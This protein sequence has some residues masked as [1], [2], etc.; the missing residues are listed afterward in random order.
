[1]NITWLHKLGC[2][3]AIS[4]DWLCN[5]SST[6]RMVHEM[7]HTWHKSWLEAWSV[8]YSVADCSIAFKLGRVL[9]H[10]KC[11][12]SKYINMYLH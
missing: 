12:R 5:V 11:S 8:T 2:K 7:K 6:N 10:C 3:F 4:V 1:M 9:S